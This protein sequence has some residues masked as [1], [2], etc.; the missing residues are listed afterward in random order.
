M[1]TRHRD[2]LIRDQFYFLLLSI[3]DKGKEML[4]Y[5]EATEMLKENLRNWDAYNYNG[6]KKQ[7]GAAVSGYLSALRR[8]KALK[9]IDEKSSPKT[10]VRGPR[11][12]EVWEETIRSLYRDMEIDLEDIVNGEY[13]F[14]YAVHKKLIL[15]EEQVYELVVIAVERY[16]LD[17][18]YVPSAYFDEQWEQQSPPEDHR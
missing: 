13:R 12:D 9:S 17:E 8:C 14:S 11:F 6:K 3:F 16:H 15:N 4:D 7:H 1:S 18:P 10:Y 5:K 2:A